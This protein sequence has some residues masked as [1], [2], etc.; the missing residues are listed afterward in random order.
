MVRGPGPDG[1]RSGRGA[2]PPLRT[3]RQ[4]MPR[5]RTVRDCAEGRLLRSRSKSHLSG[6]CVYRLKIT[7]IRS[8]AAKSGREM[9]NLVSQI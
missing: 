3:S 8:K 5:A 4:S 2:A 1:P 7:D 9:R 6:N